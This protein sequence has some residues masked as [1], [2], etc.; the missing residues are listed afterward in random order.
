MEAMMIIVLVIAIAAI[1]IWGW[2][3]AVNFVFNPLIRKLDRRAAREAKTDNPYI[4]YHR[5]KMHNDAMY[6]EYLAWMSKNSPG[7]P[8]DKVKFPEDQAF[9]RDMKEATKKWK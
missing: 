1:L 2:V 8:V 6:D 5:A 4:Q 7:V 9:D 3:K